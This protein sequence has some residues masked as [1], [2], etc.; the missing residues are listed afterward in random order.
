VGYRRQ[1]AAGPQTTSDPDSVQTL[2]EGI[3][4][5]ILAGMQTE[6]RFAQPKA[7]RISALHLDVQKPLSMRH[8]ARWVCATAVPASRPLIRA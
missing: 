2:D 1:G 4:R 6:N 3:G 5:P 7:V 8:A